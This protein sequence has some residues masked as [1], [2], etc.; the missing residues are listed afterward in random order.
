MKYNTFGRAVTAILAYLAV[1][2]VLVAIQ[3]PA[4]G[5]I[6]EAVKGVTFKG[7]PSADGKG[8]RSA[9]LSAAG[10]RLLFSERV[11]LTLTEASGA[12]HSALP[13]SYEATANGFAIRFD[14]GSIV[15]A[16]SGSEGS[17]TW[18]ITPKKPAAKAFLRYE[19]VYGA[20]LL[21]PADDG[22]LRLSVG[23]KTY[24][25]AGLSSGKAAKTFS[26][27]AVKGT[28]KPIVAAPEAAGTPASPT[29]FIAQ[30]PMDPAAWARE[31]S[32]WRDKAWAGLSGAAFNATEATWS[33]GAGSAPAFSEEAFIAYMA[34]A[35]RRGNVEA[36]AALVPVVRSKHAGAIT[37]KSVPLAG[38]STTAMTD[39][40]N[41][42]LTEVK[43]AERLVQSRSID[44]FYQRGVV[45][46]LFDRAPYS[47]AQE[48]MT[49]AR[50]LDFSKSSAAQA[51][52]LIESWL[53]ARNYLPD[54]QNPYA[55]AYELVDKA[56]TPMIRKV[57]GSFHLQT[58]ADG[59]CDT[60]IGL[61]AGKALI[62]LAES[63]DKPIYAG[64]GQSL[65]TSLLKLAG[66]DG[67]IPASVTVAGAAVVRSQDALSAAAIYEIVGDSPYYPHTVSFYK[68]LGPGAW[69]WT[70]APGIT[71]ES[72]PEKTVYSME[73]PVGSSH[74]LALYG[75][76]PFAKIQLY[77]L[78]YNM[79]ASF[80]NYNASGYFYK[81]AAGAMYLK[82]RHKSRTEDIRLYY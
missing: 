82:M 71:L 53:D 22:S 62:R 26:V 16:S 47:L 56:M 6:S 80:E 15:R 75:V 9:E 36:A 38:R 66:D 40:E 41:R 31:I 10:I 1:F 32:T 77:G 72:S 17:V 33:R 7:L 13:V 8:I 79:D 34:E 58:G 24:R 5:P 30:A 69:A 46:L 68:T 27:S 11:P 2:V 45:Q 12:E 43:T 44:L 39:F 14:D 25:I 19:L 23:E 61:Q 74:Y 49:L 37:W 64:I 76:K 21:A 52:I 73:W 42:N 3:F 48:A 54:D 28:M 29:Q 70:S 55:K 65:V 4:A 35:L 57:E 50:T 60:R 20:S 51:T 81:R 63:L 18:S 78:D 59:L 67:S